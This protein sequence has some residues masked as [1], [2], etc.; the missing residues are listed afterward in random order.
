VTAL[1]TLLT[2]AFNPPATFVAGGQPVPL[3]EVEPEKD[4]D[5]V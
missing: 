2:F 3:Q 5:P 4:A 1:V